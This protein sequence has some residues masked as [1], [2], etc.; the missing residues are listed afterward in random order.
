MSSGD[1]FWVPAK[2]EIRSRLAW[3]ADGQVSTGP[4]L[5]ERD[6]GAISGGNR[7]RGPT[8]G[9]PLM[10]KAALGEIRVLQAMSGVLALGLGDLCWLRGGSPSAGR[11]AQSGVGSAGSA[12]LGWA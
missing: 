6:P 1:L 11:V 10:Q 2:A 5:D 8:V 12:A 9:S 4:A 3:R 7:S